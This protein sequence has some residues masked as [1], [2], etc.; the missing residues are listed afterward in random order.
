MQFATLFLI[1][2]SKL[3]LQAAPAVIYM[4]ITS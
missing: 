3:E 2:K 1:L 4:Q